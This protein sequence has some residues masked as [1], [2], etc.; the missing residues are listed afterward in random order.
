MVRW[1]FVKYFLFY[2]AELL[3]AGNPDKFDWIPYKF[4]GKHGTRADLASICIGTCKINPNHGE[5]RIRSRIRLWEDRITTA[6]GLVDSKRSVAGTWLEKKPG[7]LR[8]SNCPD[9]RRGDEARQ[10]AHLLYRGCM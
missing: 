7:S 2:I 10:G 5:G 8:E 4:H 3:K 1:V 6:M 9:M